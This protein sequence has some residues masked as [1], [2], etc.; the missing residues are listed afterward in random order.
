MKTLLESLKEKKAFYAGNGVTE[1]EI[2]IAE[3][4][5]GLQFSKE[6]S[7]YLKAYGTASVY[8]HEFTGLGDTS[9]RSVVDVTMESRGNNPKA[10][11]DLYVVEEAH[12][13]G[14]LI[15]Q[16]A[17]GCVYQ[18]LPTSKPKKIADSLLNY[19]DKL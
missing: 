18:S 2:E 11:T 6:Y 14:I 3:N 19:I 16:D 4:T 17:E 7:Q 13:D 8:G 15:W 5:L 9:P 1:T 10:S 12:I